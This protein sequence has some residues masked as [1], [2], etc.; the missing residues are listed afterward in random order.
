[1]NVWT[2]CNSVVGKKFVRV[3]WTVNSPHTKNYYQG[4]KSY[5]DKNI[6]MMINSDYEHYIDL[7]EKSLKSYYKIPVKIKTLAKQGKMQIIKFERI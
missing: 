7:I 4:Y 6:P 5:V 1:M 3:G 2:E